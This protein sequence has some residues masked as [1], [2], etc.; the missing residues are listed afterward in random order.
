MTQCGA[1]Y[2]HDAVFIREA[3]EWIL[4]SDRG[5]AT[6]PSSVSILLLGLD[7]WR[8][9]VIAQFHYRTLFG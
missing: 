4:L 8:V 1:E 5:M 3:Y 7:L 9:N 2:E 6:K